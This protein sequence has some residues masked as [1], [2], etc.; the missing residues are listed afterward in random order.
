MLKVAFLSTK[1]TNT[2]GLNG[3]RYVMDEEDMAKDT[4]EK[5]FFAP[6]VLHRMYKLP[7]YAYS[8]SIHDGNLDFMS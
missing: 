8:M 3:Q 6:L 2:L 7:Y 1:R 4:D 5:I